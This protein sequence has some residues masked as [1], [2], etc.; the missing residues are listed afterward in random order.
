MTAAMK[1]KDTCSLEETWTGTLLFWQKSVQSS[2]WFFQYST[3]G[4]KSWTIW[5]GLSSKELILSNCSAAMLEKILESSL[6]SKEIKPVNPKGNYPWI[7]TGRNDQKYD[8]KN[9]FSHTVSCLFTLTNA[10]KVFFLINFNLSILLLLVLL[11][12]S[13]LDIHCQVQYHDLLLLFIL[14]VL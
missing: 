2:L 7:F 14:S 12:V 9:A 13:C 6:D 5:K 4:C 3:Y 11:L 8:L 10:Q 1:L